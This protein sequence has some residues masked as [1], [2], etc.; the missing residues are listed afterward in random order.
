MGVSWGDAL[1]VRNHCV[2]TSPATAGEL[3]VRRATLL[4][5]TTTSTDRRASL[6]ALAHCFTDPNAPHDNP[7][8]PELARPWI[9]CID[10][11]HV[12][13]FRYRHDYDCGGALAVIAEPVRV[14]ALVHLV[15]AWASCVDAYLDGGR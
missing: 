7:S 6:I 1:L 12:I 15:R 3:S 11:A 9:R 4:H 10:A 14:A 5:M 13:A 8:E 2:I